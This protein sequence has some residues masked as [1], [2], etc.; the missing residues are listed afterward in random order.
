V[1]EQDGVALVAFY[2]PWCG[3]CKNLAPAFDKAAAALQGIGSLV[4][5]DATAEKSLGSTYGVQGF[6]TIKMFGFDKKK[7]ADYQGGRDAKAIVDGVLAAAKQLAR[8][9]L[10][11]GKKPSSSSSSSSGPTFSGSGGGGGSA[12]VELTDDN[13]E[14][15]VL[16]SKDQWLVAF[17]APWCGHCKALL[18][19]W[20]KASRELKGKVMLGNV[21]ATAQ[22][23]LGSTYGVRGYPTIKWFAAGEKSGAS[24]A[25]DYQ[26]ERKAGGIVKFALEELAKSGWE[27]EVNEIFDHAQFKAQC[28][29]N[30]LCILGF[31]PSIYEDGKDGR[32][33]NIAVLKA[34]V[35]KAT[36][37][38]FGAGWVEAGAQA[39]LESTFRIGGFPSVV[40]ISHKKKTVSVFNGAFDKRKVTTFVQMLGGGKSARRVKV[41]EWPKLKTVEKWDGG[42]APVIEEEF[43]LEELMGEDL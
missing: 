39:S 13:F 26:Q 27:P 15:L 6:P 9:R 22:Q 35:A 2:A 28:E 42:E 29:E 30:Q 17:T 34:A 21:D 20:D 32:E 3:H 36:G 7:P 23:G 38:S 24:S 18:P 14:E 40:L 8:T 31:L 12:V 5:V 37:A 11:G 33:S 4:A 10:N 25:Q 1:L 41:K 16:D 43:S 19:E